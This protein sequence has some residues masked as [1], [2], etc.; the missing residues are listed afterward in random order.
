MLKR[1]T[2]SFIKD[3]RE[4]LEPGSDMCGRLIEWRWIQDK[5]LPPTEAMKLGSYFE[6]CLTGALPKNKQIPIPD[7]TQKGQLTADYQR[8]SNNAQ[9]VK[10]YLA[11]MGLV[12]VKVSVKLTKGRF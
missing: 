5:E 3:M 1:I 8:A 12:I 10:E 9:R 11:K 6:Y 7:R 2:Q 4:Y